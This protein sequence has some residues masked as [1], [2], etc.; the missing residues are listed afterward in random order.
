M[1]NHICR[2]TGTPVSCVDVACAWI[3]QCSMQQNKKNVNLDFDACNSTP[4]I[5][6][7]P[8][9]LKFT[10]DQ[11]V[12]AFALF[13]QII[14]FVQ[15]VQQIVIIAVELVLN[16]PG[17]PTFLTNR[18]NVFPVKHRGLFLVGFAHHFTDH[19]FLNL[20]FAATRRSTEIHV[21]QPIR[22]NV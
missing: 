18:F 14:L 22:H 11:Q 1:I 17:Q 2:S 10:P 3:T 13:Q 9:F 5:V 20:C 16:V 7:P 8:R 6:S 12:H 21:A 19:F 4:I 15:H